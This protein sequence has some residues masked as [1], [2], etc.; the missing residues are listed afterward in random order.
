[1]IQQILIKKDPL[2]DLFISSL[3]SFDD[4]KHRKKILVAVSGGLDSVALLYLLHAEKKH[5]LYVAHVN[6]H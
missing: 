1:M 6:H 2:F 5:D 3:S 4:L